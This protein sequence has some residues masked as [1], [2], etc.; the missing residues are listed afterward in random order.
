MKPIILC[1][2][3]E[4]TV[5][6]TV[7]WKQ[8]G[9]PAPRTQVFQRKRGRQPSALETHSFSRDGAGG[10]AGAQPPSGNLGIWKE[11]LFCRRLRNQRK[12]WRRFRLGQAEQTTPRDLGCTYRSWPLSRILQSPPEHP[13][14]TPNI[15]LSPSY[16]PMQSNGYSPPLCS[17]SPTHILAISIHP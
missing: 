9:Y 17:S 15:N 13:S 16:P 4:A 6:L 5:F 1:H 12:P 2:K 8:H 3:M 10:E 14:R 7:P 11:G